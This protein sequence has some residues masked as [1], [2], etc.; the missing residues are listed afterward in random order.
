MARIRRHA[1]LGTREARRRLRARKEP[2]WLVIE[3]GLSLGYRKS[4]EGG[5]WAVRRYDPG[6]RRHF[7]A[8]LG[9]AD[10]HRD[11]DGADVLDFAQAQRKLLA[12]AHQEALRATGQLYTVADAVKDYID[13]LHQHRKTAGDSEAKLRTYVLPQLGQRRVSEL[14]EADIETWLAWALRRR[15]K[16]KNPQKD[17]AEPKEPPPAS[18]L[19]ERQRRRKATLNRV[20]NAFK[21]CLKRAGAPEK[22]LQRLQKF[23]AV[24]SARLRWLTVDEATRLQN[25]CSPDFRPLVSAALLT[26]CRAGELLSVRARDYDP[27]SKTLLI[28]DSKSGKPRHVPLTDDG[29]TLFENLTAGKPENGTLFFRADGTAWYRMAFVRAMRDACTRAKIT[30]PATFH[31]LRHTYASHLVQAGVP[32]LF[33]AS[34]LGHSDTRMVEKHYGH[35]APSHIADTIRANLRSFGAVVTSKLRNIRRA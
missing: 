15:R 12:E 4:S 24:D 11:A 9:T 13:Y 29:A 31:T 27:H 22:V 20:I 7:E 32:L 28:A 25:A 30:P 26:G 35:L 1:D 19:A 10:D 33:V 18:E 34:A 16:S 6:R 14:T 23:R 3:K 17:G 8:R 2:Y 5:T 21:A